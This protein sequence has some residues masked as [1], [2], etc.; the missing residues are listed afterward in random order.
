MLTADQRRERYA[1]TG[2]AT[3]TGRQERRIRRKDRHAAP[4]ET[5]LRRRAA[6][7][8]VSAILARHRDW[9]RY[10]L[11]RPSETEDESEDQ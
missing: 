10:L 7:E 8:R 11:P 3:L 2:R 5:G 4:T 9:R 1:R 6:S